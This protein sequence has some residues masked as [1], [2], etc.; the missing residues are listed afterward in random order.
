[1]RRSLVVIGSLNLDLVVTVAQPPRPGETVLGGD[2]TT[3]PGGKGA[4][5]AVAAARAGAA[6]AM[7]GLVGQDTFGE[8]LQ[9]ALEVEEVDVTHVQTIPGPSGIALITV[10]QQG[11]NQ[12]VVSPGANASLTCDRIPQTL[13]QSASLILLQL[14]IP[15]ATVARVIQQAQEFGVPV[16]LNPTP[17]Q[18]L[19]LELIAGVTYLVVN[20]PEAAALT[21]LTV[22][23]PAQALAAAQVLHQQG[24]PVVIVTLG[25]QGVIW[26]SSHGQG[27]LPAYSVTVQD[28]TAAGDAFC[29]ALAAQ[30]VAGV[31]IEPAIAFANA[32]G[33]I[34]VTRVGAQP[35]LG[36]YQEISHLLAT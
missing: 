17:V 32:A 33:A 36:T 35:S 24:P 5:Q 14:E 28:T 15:L 25:E 18:P 23:T 16:L 13:L 31:G 9:T 20:Q 21:K 10:D 12:I 4:N 11:Q 3:F 27:Q 29:G 19:G 7:V 34:A 8:Q 26:V 2:Y 30:L 1:M 6:T 22:E